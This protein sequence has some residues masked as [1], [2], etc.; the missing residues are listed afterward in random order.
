MS[1]I[2]NKNSFN[3]NSIKGTIFIILSA[4]FFSLGGVLIKLI[5]WSS[6]T[7]Q[8]VRSVFST[9]V[10]VVYMILTR[11]R[12]K[13]NISV[14]T[15]AVLNF[16][17]AV[18]FVSATK[19]TTAA[20]A[21]VL[22]FTEPIFVILLLWIIYK[23][24]P[25]KEAVITCIIVFAGILCFFFESLSTGGIF[26]NV[27][28]IISGASYAG[29][30]L[31][32][33][34][35]NGDFESSLVVSN[36]LSIVAGIPAFAGESEFSPEIW[37]FVIILGSVQFGLSYIFLSK[38]LDYVSPVTA[39]L[40]STIE[41]ILNPILVAIFYGET[42]GILSVVGAVMVIGSALAYSLGQALMDNR[43]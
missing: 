3:K 39:S 11:H 33:G 21:I 7:I 22:Q 23:K 30:F 34:F 43:V 31:I 38:G 41:P 10:I 12:F 15:G 2:R 18:T 17:M 13:I 40:T 27:L 26:G 16:V 5:P 20:N 32:K 6:L 35:K 42:I 36:L 37:V 1:E 19:L 24:R 9:I 29:V 28:A 4:I 8:S 25:S 14:L